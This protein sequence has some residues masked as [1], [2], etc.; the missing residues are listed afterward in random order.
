MMLLLVARNDSFYQKL[1]CRMHNLSTNED[2]HTPVFTWS[3][4]NQRTKRH[5]TLFT[6]HLWLH[7]R[8]TRKRWIWQSHGCDRPWIYKEGNFYP[9]Q[10]DNWCHAHGTKL[11]WNSPLA[12][13]LISLILSTMPLS[14]YQTNYLFFSI[15][16]L[17]GLVDIIIR[18][19]SYLALL[20]TADSMP[21]YYF[22]L[23]TLKPYPYSA[24]LYSYSAISLYVLSFTPY[25]L[26]FLSL[27]HLI[28]GLY[29]I[30]GYLDHILL[31]D[32]PGLV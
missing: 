3:N 4:T 19:D 7:H 9:L 14:S 28:A 27:T 8:P 29:F 30:G 2:Q 20:H 17:F 18:F 32:K 5:K 26:I 6:S 31:D 25:L 23:L 1:C 24:K 15:L 12:P 13:Y 21:S 11:L 22:I 10:Q 16:S